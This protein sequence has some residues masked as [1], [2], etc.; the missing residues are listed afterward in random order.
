MAFDLNHGRIDPFNLQ[1][2]NS[3]F[4]AYD[5]S[6]RVAAMILLTMKHAKIHQN[7]NVIKSQKSIKKRHRTTYPHTHIPTYPHTHI[8]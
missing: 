5:K 7:V 3:A 2:S 1:S 4:S 6:V 8:Q